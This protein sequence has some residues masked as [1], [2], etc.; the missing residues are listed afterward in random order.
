MKSYNHEH[1]TQEFD[2]VARKS[3]AS[4]MEDSNGVKGLKMYSKPFLF[5]EE[6]P[7]SQM[8]IPTEN[9]IPTPEINT[10][11]FSDYNIWKKI[12]IVLAGLFIVYCAIAYFVG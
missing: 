10:E 2:E 8:D 11:R 4:N 9:F 1:Y 6:R 5:D 3:Y 7:A 12:A